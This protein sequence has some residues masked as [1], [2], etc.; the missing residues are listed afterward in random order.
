MAARRKRGS[1]DPLKGVM[2]VAVVARLIIDLLSM[3]NR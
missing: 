2:A 1:R 3:F